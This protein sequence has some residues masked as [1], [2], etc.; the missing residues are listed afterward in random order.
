VSC[1]NLIRLS[2]LAAIV[3]GALLLVGDLLS[4]A[5]ESENRSEAATTAP[6]V[7]TFLLYLI[8][9]VLLL[10]GLVGLYIRQS[11]ASG[12]LGLVGFAAAFLGEALV[13][14][15]VWTELFVAPFLA[16]AAPAV[17]D[18]GPTGT[19]AVGFILT[20]ALGAL[21]WLLFGL[22][23]LRARVYP[24][25]AAIALMVGA[26]ISFLPIPASGIVLNAV[27]AWLGF[28]LLTGTG[29]VDSDEQPARVR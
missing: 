27:V 4:L 18:A 29:A 15:A 28:T 7:F 20:F 9:T 23:A 22:A 6:F 1:S 12:I 10:V 13:L 16:N 8:G 26:V 21:G 14:G 19:L 25:A 5:T 11:E 2:G 24:R 3:A 17:L